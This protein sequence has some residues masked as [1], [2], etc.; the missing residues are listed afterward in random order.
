MFSNFESVPADRLPD[1]RVGPAWASTA[2]SSSKLVQTAGPMLILA[3]KLDEHWPAAKKM[4]GRVAL[5]TARRAGKLALGVNWATQQ[6]AG[7]VPKGDGDMKA[8]IPKGKR[9][10]GNDERG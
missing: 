1:A 8:R 3:K 5:A 2:L 10:C 9:G 4:T 7:F 6:L